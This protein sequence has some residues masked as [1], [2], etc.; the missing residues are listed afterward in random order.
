MLMPNRNKKFDRWV[1]KVLKAMK[2]VETFDQ[3]CHRVG[4]ESLA[5]H[6]LNG[7]NPKDIAKEYRD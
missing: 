7:A 1:S 6:Y 4:V 5:Y 3:L 2:S